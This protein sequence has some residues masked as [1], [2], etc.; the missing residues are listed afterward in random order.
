MVDAIS[1]QPTVELL[2]VEDAKRDRSKEDFEIVLAD[3]LY[4]DDLVG[5]RAAD[6]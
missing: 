6:E 3:A 1:K 2:L 5:E 4:A